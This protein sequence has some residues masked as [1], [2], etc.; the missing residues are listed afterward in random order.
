MYLLS[1]L[2]RSARPYL[3]PAITVNSILMSAVCGL[4]LPDCFILAISLVLCA[5]A[6]FLFNDLLDREIDRA[7][8][9]KRLQDLSRRGCIMV[10]TCAGASWTLA[11][12]M[13]FLLTS[14]GQAIAILLVA[15][16]T[17]FYSYPIRSIPV[18]STIVSALL[19]TSPIWVP[20]LIANE[21]TSL[22]CGLLA[23]SALCLIIGRETILDIRDM[24]GDRKHGRR[25]VPVLLGRLVAVRISQVFVIASCLIVCPIPFLVDSTMAR[26]L[27][28]CAWI[29]YLAFCLIPACQISISGRNSIDAFVRLS[30][31]AL[32]VNIPLICL[33]M[34]TS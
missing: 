6:G 9:R 3:W 31:R 8:G 12:L 2:S 17:A 4:H 16:G 1:I 32:L 25:T 7:N 24:E 27:V 34:L 33:A 28:I 29:C 15:L 13:P 30:S 20:M 11:L 18:V 14:S 22:T 5:S 10:A 21:P 23:A 26:I 19:C